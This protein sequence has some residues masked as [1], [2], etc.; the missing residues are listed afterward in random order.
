VFA[1]DELHWDDDVFVNDLPGGSS[2]LRRP[3]GGYRYTLANGEVTQEDGVLTDVRPAGV[4][5]SA[6]G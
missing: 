2:R 5:H 3:P 4:L 6:T 1:L